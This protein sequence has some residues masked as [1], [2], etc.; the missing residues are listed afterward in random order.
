[1]NRTWY[2][3]VFNALKTKLYLKLGEGYKTLYR[4]FLIFV[5]L[6]IRLNITSK[7]QKAL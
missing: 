2:H 7:I 1:M 3:S 5:L 6:K 4:T